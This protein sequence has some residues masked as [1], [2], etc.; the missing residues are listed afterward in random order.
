VVECGD[1]QDIPG[2]TSTYS[3]TTGGSNV[4]YTCYSGFTFIDEETERVQICKRLIDETVAQTGM[5][6]WEVPF[7]GPYECFGKN[8]II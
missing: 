7:S 5:W 6:Q 2:A 1:P 4:T 3:L 8:N